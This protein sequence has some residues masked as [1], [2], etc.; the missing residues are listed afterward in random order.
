MHL[1]VC[2]D[3]VPGTRFFWFSQAFAWGIP[4]IFANATLFASGVSF[5]FGNACF[6][7][8]QNAMVFWAPL[9]VTGGVAVMV[10][11]ATF[12]YC[13]RVYLSNVLK[14]RHP[15]RRVSMED[16]RSEYLA[17]VTKRIAAVLRLQWR[18]MLLVIVVLME[19]SLF[20]L[21]F[22]YLDRMSENV[23]DLPG[24]FAPWVGC[25]IEHRDK[26]QCLSLLDGLIVKESVA[27]AAVILFSLVSIVI[28]ALLIQ[29]STFLSWSNLLR[30]KKER[31]S[32]DSLESAKAK[33]PQ[34][35]SVSDFD[36]KT[37]N[38]SIF[39]VK[40][41]SVSTFEVKTPVL[42]T[43][44]PTHDRFS[45]QRHI[46]TKPSFVSETGSTATHATADSSQL[47][48]IERAR[49]GFEWVTPTPSPTRTHFRIS[50]GFRGRVMTTVSRS[51]ES[52]SRLA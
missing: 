48:R 10:Q 13:A 21:L 15:G 47:A 23:A 51:V 32:I 29:P 39:E 25:M 8:H 45:F 2:W 31:N 43:P 22:I 34:T 17:A 7:H 42:T 36:A 52:V 3:K 46:R 35:P 27:N 19:L 18:S 44:T 30:G 6:P 26:N 50:S 38:V 1:Q 28:F 20:C 14:R 4:L 33:W 40:T 24:H 37:P 12:G 49:S 41:P 11:L 9:I 16:L 5:R